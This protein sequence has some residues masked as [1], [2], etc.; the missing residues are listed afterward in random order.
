[1]GMNNA[2]GK[3]WGHLDGWLPQSTLCSLIINNHS[4]MQNK[5][6]LSQGL[7]KPL[8]PPLEQQLKIQNLAI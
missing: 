4:Y 3:H 7:Q 1:M 5:L 6:T 8:R 2:H